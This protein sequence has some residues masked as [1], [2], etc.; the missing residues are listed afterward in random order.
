MSKDERLALL[1]D[2]PFISAR[3]F[4][5][6]IDTFF[7]YIINGK[8]KPL[9]DIIDYWIRIEFQERQTP[10]MHSLLSVQSDNNLYASM[11]NEELK[12]QLLNLVESI[13]SASLQERTEGN[14]DDINDIESKEIFLK[15]E[16]EYYYNI[17]H[18]TYF[19]DTNHPNREPFI[20]EGFDYS[21][22]YNIKDSK[23][24]DKLR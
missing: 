13:T 11:D 7:K 18:S 3:I 21:Y 22:R 24:K 14:I 23:V 12:K 4:D 2:H 20:F 19:S 5:R 15:S 9:G 17:D 8:D 10:H 16:K 6:F 1:R